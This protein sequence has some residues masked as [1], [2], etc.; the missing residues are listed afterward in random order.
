MYL[1][2]P[3]FVYASCVLD[4]QSPR[5]VN[6]PPPSPN[7]LISFLGICSAVRMDRKLSL[8]MEMVLYN[9]SAAAAAPP[10]EA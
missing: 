7:S 8:S 1:C 9:P 5:W 4:G 6:V 10:F 3:H 2:S